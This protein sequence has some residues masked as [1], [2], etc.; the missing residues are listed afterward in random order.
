MLNR[1]TLMANR[2]YTLTLTKEEKTFVIRTQS[3]ELNDKSFTLA[4]AWHFG[5]QLRPEHTH[6][7]TH[8]PA[9][10]HRHIYSENTHTHTHTH[11]HRKHTHTHIYS[12]HTHTHTHTHTHIYSEN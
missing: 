1:R 7:H 8:H 4:F 5:T 2:K 12:K 10:T 11:I 6:T 9:H 3:L